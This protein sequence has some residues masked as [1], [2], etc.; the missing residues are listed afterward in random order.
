MTHRPRRT[1]A[2]GFLSVVL[3]TS[4]IAVPLPAAAVPVPAPSG[5]R[6]GDVLIDDD[7]HSLA[8]AGW[9]LQHA[10]RAGNYITD[11]ANS[12]GNPAAVTMKEV[13]RGQYLL[14]SAADGLSNTIKKTLPIGGGAWTIDFQARFADLATP[15]ANPTW[16][17]FT[18]DTIADGRRFRVTFNGE[19]S[20]FAVQISEGGSTYRSDTIATAGTGLHD[21][22]IAYDGATT[23]SVSMDG[24]L[25]ARSSAVTLTSGNAD[26]VILYNSTTALASGTNEVYLD[27]FRFTKGGTH[28]F[29]ET[30]LSDDAVSLAA[31]EWSAA[32]PPQTDLYVTDHATT[33]GNPAQVPLTSVP[34]GQ[35]ILVGDSATAA[36]GTASVTR[37]VPLGVDQ[38]AVSLRARIVDLTAGAGSGFGVEIIA[39]HQAFT[40][41]LSGDGVLTARRGTTHQQQAVVLPSDDQ[42]HT[43][44]VSGDGHGGIYVGL[45][46]ILVAQFSGIGEPSTDGDRL[47]LSTAVT[48]GATGRTEVAL[49]SITARS[50]WM[51]SWADAAADP[52]S[53]ANA[54]Q[55]LLD[56]AERMTDS[57]WE[58]GGAFSA[59]NHIA[60]FHAGYDPAN[61][62]LSAVPQGRFRLL[63]DAADTWSSITKP[64][65][66]GSAPWMLEA[67]LR[68]VDLVT[69]TASGDV[70]GVTF[71]VYANSRLSRVRLH[72]MT[73]GV[74]TVSIQQDDTGAMQSTQVTMPADEDV[75]Q[76]GIGFDG[77]S[78]ITVV[79][80]GG[81]VAAATGVT[82]AGTGA[83]RL[84]IRNDAKSI[85]AGRNH[86]EID[87]IVAAKGR[88]AEWVH[89]AIDDDAGSLAT[90]GWARST[91]PVEG[92][93][94]TDHPVSLGN[95]HGVQMLPVD[96]GQYL[97]SSTTSGLYSSITKTAFI[98]AGAWYTQ[99]NARIE[100]L[101]TPST[102][103]AWRGFS[104]DLFAAATR[105]RVSFHSL[106]ASG[107]MKISLLKPGSGVQTATVSAPAD[108][109]FHAWGIRYD[110]SS[111]LTIDLDGAIVAEFTYAV[112]AGT[113]TDRLVLYADT[114]NLSSGATEVYVDR[115]RVLRNLV[116]RLHDPDPE[117][118]TTLDDPADSMQNA[119]W[120]QVAPKTGTYITDSTN[121][122]GNP[123]GVP[124]ASVPAGQ[125]LVYGDDSAASG[126]YTTATRT[127]PFGSGAWT[128]RF[129]AK[130]LDLAKP[131]T[132]LLS[133]GLAFSVFAGGRRFNVS[134][135]GYDAA[136]GTVKAFIGNDVANQ[137]TEQTVFLPEGDVFNRWELVY[138][139]AGTLHLGMNEAT[140][141]SSRT[142]GIAATG[143]DRIV[144][145]NFAK[146]A[147]TTGTNNVLFDR[148]TVRR[149]LVPEW[150][151]FFPSVSGVSI[152]PG[153]DSSS[154]PIVVNVTGVDPAWFDDPTVTVRA[155]LL[156]GTTQLSTASVPLTAPTVTLDLTAPGHT[157]E[158]R[159]SVEIRKDGTT[160]DRIDKTIDLV[161]SSETLLPDGSAT[162]SPGVVHLFDDVGAMRNTAAQPAAAAGWHEAP[163]SYRGLDP[164]ASG[165]E[166]TLI[167]TT[168][169]STPLQLPAQLH[170]WFA[171]YVGY[172]SGTDGF[173][174]E[175]EGTTKA[176]TFPDK[177]AA[178]YSE[179]ALREEFVMAA[180]FDGS[181]PIFTP[182]PGQTARIAY[183]RLRGMTADDIALYNT[184]D[185]GAAGKR[186][187]YNN[188]GYTHFTSLKYNSAAS[189]TERAVGLYEGQ[190]VGAIDWAAGT[191]MQLNY[192]SAHAGIP[193]DGFGEDDP[194]MRE[195]DLY[196]KAMIR[197]IHGETGQ[198]APAVLA[199][200]ADA[201]GMDFNVSLRME[202]FYSENLSFL[203]GKTYEQF[204]TPADDARQLAADGTTRGYRLSYDNESFRDYVKDV[205]A[206]AAAFPGVDG[207]NLDFCRYPN[208]FG[209][210]LTDVATRKA[211]ITALI[212]EIRA[213]LPG[214]TISVRIP[215]SNYEGYGLDPQAWVDQD[216]IDIL[217]PSNVSTEDFFDISPF[218]TMVSGSSVKLYGGIVADLGGGDLTKEQ[219]AILRNGG[220]IPA[221]KKRLGLT[222]Y[223]ERAH[224]LYEA[225]VDGLYIFN[226]WWNDVGQFGLLGDK[227]EVRKW[228][229]FDSFSQQI[230][231]SIFIQTPS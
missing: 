38:W 46:D 186:V 133:R 21:W 28:R 153:A 10:P 102:N 24:V 211:R 1:F 178:G 128:F 48:A 78:T 207:V 89:T 43:W 25:V 119:G 42:F 65:A 159:L 11:A 201:A 92:N 4:L 121:S 127:T 187:I 19:A 31:S 87:K 231:N 192:A 219:E 124:L 26:Q 204:I 32:S 142:T 167:E 68:I 132:N 3:M 17:G 112:V 8:D 49:D 182:T 56:F 208:V 30:T 202:A 223:Q 34:N 169:S 197:N 181:A 190:D 104:M 176:V 47:S 149:G 117:V 214:T 227:V 57:G 183:V 86:V 226:S 158:T 76:W 164:S 23:I 144:I 40:L 218:V 35:Y 125:Y 191:T 134:L 72:S 50:G 172:A 58:S 77:A 199:S 88:I 138:D 126:T 162:S 115:I 67:D 170:G 98:G 146:D 163:F 137:F 196:A 143:S 205:L 193:F 189:L 157:G 97:F 41:A 20:R 107:D 95:P 225:G 105:F 213:L 210:E 166:L 44:T 173:Q 14:Y 122:L 108:G 22:G 188:D 116:P 15:S 212:S 165:N 55:L 81:V 101:P 45:D 52:Y 141:I 110:G 96:A 59:N 61:S 85:A 217:I 152:Q 60:D 156:D 180:D 66:F 154:V 221:L 91:A 139:G 106:D 224:E 79:L 71:E 160:A 70:A 150:T 64:L 39:D 130:I 27:S 12:L 185:E 174:V 216:L 29:S 222:Q 209:N 109:G 118:T 114:T 80:D 53:T 179:Q 129:D 74:L 220:T 18:I 228:H 206:E 33:L 63:A 140:V 155:R 151:R 9:T 136:A 69:P 198:W 131:T 203:N 36:A 16:N 184:P 82:T 215:Y 2:L 194:H 7:A 123:A 120:T 94:I 84:V 145:T 168:P 73:N 177:S 5:T 113:G 83:D 200:A 99:L 51:P 13:I 171:V 93:Y 103:L 90:A 100:E 147:T 62:W 75:H 230:E 54:T 161:S 111:A 135:S 175:A 229:H 148:F 6:G 37:P 195:I